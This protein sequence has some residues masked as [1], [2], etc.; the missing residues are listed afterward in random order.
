MAGKRGVAHLPDLIASE[1]EVAMTLLTS[2][3]WP[4]NR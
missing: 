2:P 4:A 1:I 3:S